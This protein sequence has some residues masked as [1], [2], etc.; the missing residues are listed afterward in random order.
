M[1]EHSTTCGTGWPE[2]LDKL[3]ASALFW[4]AKRKGSL[5]PAPGSE[6]GTAEGGGSLP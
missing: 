1:E 2:V 3:C 4:V 6:E 5:A